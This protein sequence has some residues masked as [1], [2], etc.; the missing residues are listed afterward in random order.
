[1]L[2]GDLY[3]ADDPELGRQSSGGMDLMHPYSATSIRAVG[4]RQHVLR[5]SLGSI[6]EGTE[7]RRPRDAHGD[8]RST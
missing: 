5:D 7:I 8:D 6:G 4:R 3:I 1:M 2:A